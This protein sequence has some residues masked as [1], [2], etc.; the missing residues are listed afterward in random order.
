MNIQYY[1]HSCFKVVT[2]PGGRN[3]ENI[4]I[5]ID[6]F[7]KYIGLK[8]PQGKADAVFVSHTQHKDHN[9]KDAIKGDPVV[10]ETAGEFSVGG[11]NV[12][13]IDSFHDDKEG[14]E[15]GRNTIFTLDTEDIRICHLGDL[16]TNLSSRQLEKIGGVDI[17]MVPVG[18]NFTI[19]GK[20]AAKI[21]QKLEPSLIIPMHF[22][23]K[24]LKLDIA[25]EKEF[26]NEIG[27]CPKERVNKITIKKKELL[28]KNLDVLL[29]KA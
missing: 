23:V 3:T 22:K 11:I 19:D 17:L 15:R 13:G 25:D 5:F 24:D 16:G 7:D 21:C 8:P 2:K 12:T 20:M 10:F 29:M 14:Q 4:T 1:G 9:N 26:C 6:P 27:D 28:D 18:G